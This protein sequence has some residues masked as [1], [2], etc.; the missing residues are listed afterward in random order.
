[1]IKKLTEGQMYCPHCGKPVSKIAE[2]C[3]ECGVR[4]KPV[5]GAFDNWPDGKKSRVIAIILGVLLGPWTWLYTVKVDQNKFILNI[6]LSVVTC[7]IW[8]MVAWVWA[9]VDVVTRADSFY[10][11]FPNG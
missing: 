3:P 8:S 2:I 11:N 4:I 9:I 10:E 7:G 1:M 6:V 5:P